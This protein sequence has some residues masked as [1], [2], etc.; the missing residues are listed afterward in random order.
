[1]DRNLFRRIE[2]AFPVSSELKRRV[3][4]DLELY[5]TDDSQA[6]NLS[7][8]GSY[9]RAASGAHISAQSRLLVLYDDRA[10]LSEA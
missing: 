7:S 4:D 2:V 3:R 5:L 10:A 1:M 8:D 6:W 9:I